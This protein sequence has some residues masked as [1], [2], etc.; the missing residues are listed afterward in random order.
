MEGLVHRFSLSWVRDALNVNGSTADPARG[1]PGRY[2]IAWW[3]ISEGR[4]VW[5]TL[6]GRR[7][8]YGRILLEVSDI[9]IYI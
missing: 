6:L 3:M 2:K 5:I 9:H 4:R 8:V 7:Y 1:T